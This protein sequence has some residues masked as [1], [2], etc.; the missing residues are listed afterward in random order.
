MNSV[1]KHLRLVALFAGLFAMLSGFAL[2][3]PAVRLDVSNN[4]CI[5]EPCPGSVVFPTTVVAGTPFLIFVAALDAQSARDFTYTGTVNFSST[6]PLASL[7]SSFTFTSANEGGTRGGLTTV[8]RTIG[9]QT[10]TVTDAASKL[11]PGSFVMT[12]KATEPVPTISEWAVILLFLALAS[13]GVFL[14][15]LR[16]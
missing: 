9:N 4:P 7:P 14:T 1:A 8:L 11:L 10:I 5:A 13:A 12:V 15:R 2:A 3:G 16:T 6:D